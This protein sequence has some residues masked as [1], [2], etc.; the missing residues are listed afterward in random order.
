VVDIPLVHCRCTE[1]DSHLHIPARRFIW[2]SCSTIHS[3]WFFLFKNCFCSFDTLQMPLTPKAKERHHQY[4][5][6]MMIIIIISIP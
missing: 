3:R 6:M 1:P 4:T 2:V 5:L